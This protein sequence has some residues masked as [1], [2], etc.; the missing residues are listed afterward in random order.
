MRQECSAQ[1]H[2]YRLIFERKFLEM[3]T[4]TMCTNDSESHE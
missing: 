2:R 1:E 4:L 3:T